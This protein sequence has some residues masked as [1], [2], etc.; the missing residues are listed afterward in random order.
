MKHA[1]VCEDENFSL[2]KGFKVAKVFLGKKALNEEEEDK[3]SFEEKVEWGS[4][5]GKE[6][7]KLIVSMKDLNPLAF[8]KIVSSFLNSNSLLKNLTLFFELTIFF[9]K[10]WHLSDSVSSEV[11]IADAGNL[12]EF[13]WKSRN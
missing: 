9:W 7:S 5:G 2:D 8:M 3:S 12:D 4:E 10:S 13:R 11:K 1:G 6:L